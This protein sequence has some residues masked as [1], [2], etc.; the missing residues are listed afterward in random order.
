MELIKLGGELLQ[1]I[2]NQANT[3]LVLLLRCCSPHNFLVPQK[4]LKLTRSPDRR[5]EFNS[6]FKVPRSTSV[7][8]CRNRKSAPLYVRSFIK[9]HK[10]ESLQIQTV[11]RIKMI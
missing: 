5:S 2:E 6:P 1:H 9:Q 7:F 4:L 3:S 10:Q 11:A 8:I